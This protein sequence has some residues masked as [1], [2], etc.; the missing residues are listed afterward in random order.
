MSDN[1][2]LSSSTDASLNEIQQAQ[3]HQWLTV[4]QRFD[5]SSNIDKLNDSLRSTT[6]LLD[7]QEPSTAD[8]I[9]FARMTPII[10]TWSDEQ[11]KAYRHIA[12]WAD[13]VQ[14]AL[15]LEADRQIKINADLD[16]PRETKQKPK[17]DA[18]PSAV[19]AAKGTP[20]APAESAPA[21]PAPTEGASAPASGDA[22]PKD[23]KKKE[24][25]PKVKKPQPEKKEVPITPGMIDLRVGFIEKAIKHPDADSLY[26]S[27]IQ[28]GDEDGSTRTVCSGLVKHFTLEEMQQRTVI[29]VANLKP[30]TMR[31]IKSCAM[32]L[33]A[34]NADDGVVE[35]VNPPEGSKP[36]DKIFF[37]TYD[38]DP[39]PVLNPKKKIWETIQ[40]GFRTNDKF[41]VTYRKDESEEPK[42][43]V[44]K[45]GELCHVTSLV[46][47]P[48][49]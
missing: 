39:E 1:S 9:V 23:G 35:F 42:R 45:K 49:R 28:M 48:V 10:K 38:S 13:L 18:K 15:G 5:E 31:G 30:V 25:K 34:N 44:N 8:S 16:V 43:L 27:T 21:T 24:K 37:E 6:Y 3:Y 2:T 20:A 41:E 32:V 40:P 33:C 4:S 19:P 26:V 29:V 12:R 36:G 46:D 22:Q 17:K 11:F 7:T 14:N 47:A